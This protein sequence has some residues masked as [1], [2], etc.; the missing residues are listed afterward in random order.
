MLT[1]RLQRV[2][3]KKFPT[4]RLVVSENSRDPQARHLEIVG[5]YNPHDKEKGLIIK[6]DR[7][8]HWLDNGAQT[9][10]TVGNLLIKLGILKSDKRKSVTISNKRTKKLDEKKTKDVEAKKLAVEKAK[11]AAEAKKA[12]EAQKAEEAKEEKEEV[13]EVEQ[14]VEE[15][16]VP[17]EKAEEADT[18]EKK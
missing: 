14:P 5:S 13:V 11:E 10:S 4:Y 16:T 3:K 8:K 15:K 1:I 18:E 9:S 12:E 7:V 6:E 17:E 2:G